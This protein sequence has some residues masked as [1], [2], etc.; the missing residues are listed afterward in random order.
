MAEDPEL[1][2]LKELAKATQ[3]SNDL[4]SEIRKDAD[5]QAK[6]NAKMMGALIDNDPAAMREAMVEY[7]RGKSPV[8][9]MEL[10]DVGY[11]S[12]RIAQGRPQLGAKGFAQRLLTPQYFRPEKEID[13]IGYRR[14]LQLGEGGGGLGGFAERFGTKGYSLGAQ[15]QQALVPF[16][17]AGAAFA[18]DEGDRMV[19]SGGKETLG[20][21][22]EE[23]RAALVDPQYVDQMQEAGL[24][25]PAQ[26]KKVKRS[27]AARRK[28]LGYA[29]DKVL[30]PE[31]LEGLK[32]VQTY[33]Q[34]ILGE[35]GNKGTALTKL[36]GLGGG[37]GEIAETLG[38]QTGFLGG[39]KA[40]ALFDI[41][42]GMMAGAKA[43]AGP[44]GIALTAAQMAYQGVDKLYG[45]NRAG[46]S[47]G[48]GFSRNPLDFLMSGTGANVSLGRSI[49][50]QMDALTSF[51]LSAEQ[52]AAA[53]AAVEGMGLGGRGNEKAYDSYYKSMTSVMENTG[54][55]SQTL[56]PFYEQFMRAG[57]A[58]KNI[59]NLTKLL[60]DDL[61][62]AAN[63]S[64]QSLAQMAQTL[65]Q[66]TQVAM[67]SPYNVRTPFEVQ[68][69]VTQAFE[70][71]APKGMENIAAGGNM[72]V[73]SMAA[74]SR[75][76]S[77]FQ[78]MQNPEA[79]NIAAADL[80]RKTFGNMDGK[81]FDEYRKTD[82]GALKV[83]QVQ[84]M[85]GMDVSTMSQIY[86]EGVTDF[87]S[88][89]ALAEK[90]SSGNLGKMTGTRIAAG[91]FYD[92]KSGEWR[93]V[94][95]AID[96][97]SQ[98]IAGTNIDIYRNK[99]QAIEDYYK[100]KGVIKT[101]ESALQSSGNKEEYD[102]FE[103]QL[104]EASTKQGDVAYNVI[105]KEAMK[106]AGDITKPGSGDGQITLS[107]EARRFFK[108]NFG[109]SPAKKTPNENYGP[110]RI[111]T[112]QE[113]A[114]SYG[115]PTTHRS[116]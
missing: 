115:A 31:E 106:V 97:R 74:R 100:G 62:K 65:Q 29:E 19:Y 4:L 77:I 22:S 48:Y 20:S 95:K 90:F 18:T 42:G 86:S 53:R 13:Y 37:L 2:V 75:G 110:G 98:K 5:R 21:L 43:I 68:R 63:Q 70:A 93:T 17:P 47:L 80:M 46:A 8:Q 71:G 14:A 41:G 35:V 39:G 55:D 26:A 94:D 52:T 64:R 108:L 101:I 11:Q 61:P 50:T 38:G 33:Q 59:E 15:I 24:I 82:A 34:T 69:D 102:S 81:S 83:M 105:R 66:A 6:L 104:K 84:A 109:P 12:Q 27:L 3:K 7:S 79:M 96:T 103:K 113:I 30:A 89:Q 10:S 107:D 40:A 57:G 60:R 73:A 23:Q 36:K 112:P 32:N 28:K 44:V 56:S 51:G 45:M 67:Q 78:A 87:E 72:F 92:K 25:S 16:R 111:A 91:T 88:A 76:T 99:G 114:A 54:L 1:K 116:S 9:D 58:N 49:Q 85:T